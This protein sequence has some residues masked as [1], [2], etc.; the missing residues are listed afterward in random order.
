R[1]PEL[2]EGVHTLIVIVS[3]D[4][5]DRT[6]LSARFTTTPAPP[7]P[8]STTER[9]PSTTVPPP[10][11]RVPPSSSTT[12]PA[13]TT[14]TTKP[15]LTTTTPS[16]PTTT[17][18]TTKP[19]TTTTAKPATTTTAPS[20]GGRTAG[21]VY[22]GFSQGL[23]WTYRSDADMNRE[24]DE[25]RAVGVAWL[26]ADVP[27]STAQPNGRGTP[28]DWAQSDRWVLAALSRGFKVLPILYF[29]PAWPRPPG[30]SDKYPASDI[31][32]WAAYISAA[33][34]HYSAMG[35]GQFEIWNE[36]N[37]DGFFGTAVSPEQYTELLKVAY[38]AAKAVNPNA[39]IV[40]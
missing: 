14:T 7:P 32:D 8:P 18:P 6:V 15:A 10:S 37:L 2:G 35:V 25:M 36:P 38:I 1:T 17:K 23:S 34:E 29:T 12:K 24:L 26:R 40:S 31:N 28:F 9:P 16:Q 30:T 13:T 27:W 4:T 39:F 33:V 19:A 22:G 5:G 11:S 3:L 21:Q 20:G